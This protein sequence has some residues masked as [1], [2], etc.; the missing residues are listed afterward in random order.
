M[1]KNLMNRIV[2]LI[3]G[4]T[5]LSSTAWANSME[6]TRAMKLPGSA[7]SLSVGQSDKELLI[8]LGEEGIAWVDV[9]NLRAPYLNKQIKTDSPVTGVAYGKRNVLVGM[10]DGSVALVDLR[11]GRI[12][13]SGKISALGDGAVQLSLAPKGDQVLATNGSRAVLIDLDKKAAT[14]GGLEVTPLAISLSGEGIEF[15]GEPNPIRGAFS[16]DGRNLAVILQ[17]NNAVAI[18]D[19][20]SKKVSRIF[21]LGETRHRADLTYDGVPFV[22]Q[23]FTGRLEAGDIVFSP[24]GK[25]LYTANEGAAGV[26]PEKDGI[27]SG[28]R[29]FSIF[30]VNGTLEYDGLDKLEQSALVLGSYPD[31]QSRVRGIEPNGVGTGK[32]KDKPALAISA[33]HANG[34]FFFMIETY[35]NPFFIGMVAGGGRKPV[36]VNG[37]RSQDGFVAVDEDG[38]L[39]TYLPIYNERVRG[40]G[41]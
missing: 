28:G 39:S 12:L 16:P 27:W 41:R 20:T 22:E 23:A 2:P 24:D 4:L 17:K 5:L 40:T 36:A 8:G 33:R 26:V 32:I 9:R 21:S 6:R 25:W 31:S 15:L 19:M 35:E 37:F 18:V 38:F 3:L 30:S 11:K 34:I 14:V 13:S 10:A 7:T 29:N 1:K